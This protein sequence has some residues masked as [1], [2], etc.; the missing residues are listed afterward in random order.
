LCSVVYSSCSMEG[1][2]KSS[3][4]SLSLVTIL[5]PALR[6]PKLVTFATSQTS[7][8]QKLPWIPRSSLSQSSAADCGTLSSVLLVLMRWSFF[9][10]AGLRRRAR[11]R[12][13]PDAGAH[14]K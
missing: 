10:E 1:R 3:S 2:S 9:F 4:S 6:S 5:F 8:S 13:L 7:R 12:A 14:N 11:A